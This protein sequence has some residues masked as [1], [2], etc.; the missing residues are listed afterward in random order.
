MVRIETG[1]F[2]GVEG[3]LLRMKGVDRL[4]VSVQLLQ[5]SVAVEID[6]RW[7]L[8][9]SPTS[10]AMAAGRKAEAFNYPQ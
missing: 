1:P 10:R 2:Y 9:C 7:V 6:R 3:I 8:P 4:V 5:R